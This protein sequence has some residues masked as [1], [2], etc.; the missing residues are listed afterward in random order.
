MG[1]D[2]VCFIVVHFPSKYGGAEESQPGR[3]AAAR[4]LLSA[5]DSGRTTIA[6]GD[7]NEQLVALMPMVQPFEPVLPSNAKNSAGVGGTIKFKGEWE[8]IDHFFLLGGARLKSFIHSPS[9]L[10]EEDKTYLGVKPFRTFIG[11]KY[12]GGVSDHL[13]IVLMILD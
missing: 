12:N 9:F 6:M 1:R 2:T 5:A 3:E 11:P 13:P 7:F 10:L 8:S 4:V